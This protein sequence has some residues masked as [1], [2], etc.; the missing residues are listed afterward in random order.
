MTNTLTHYGV[1]G[2][3]WGIRRYQP[4][5][6]GHS[7]G[8]EVGEAAKKTKVSSMSDE[9]LTKSVR[10]LNL[11]QQYQKMTKEKPK[12][13]K[14]E[15]AK[16]VVDSTSKL[17]NKAQEMNNKSIKSKSQTLDLSSMTDQELRDK[18]NRYNLEKQYNDIFGKNSQN[19]SKGQEYVAKTLD[20]AG[21]VVGIVGSAIAIALSIKSLKG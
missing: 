13:S 1:Q 16:N 12:P 15:N 21:D 5:P 17:V 19:V 11:E 4:Y 18:I 2:M 7:G 9:E 20:V 3:H 10:R 14:L 6:D 8:K